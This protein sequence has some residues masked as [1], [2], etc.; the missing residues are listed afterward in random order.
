[1]RAIPLT[2]GKVAL[3]DDADYDRISRFKWYAR[4]GSRASVFYANRKVNGKHVGMHNEIMGAAP[5]PSM[6][7]DHRDGN[8]LNN[9]RSNLRWATHAQQR[10]NI[11][12]AK[13]NTSGFKGVRK[14][15]SPPHAFPWT[16]QIHVNRKCLFLGYFS[17]LGTAAAAYNDAALKYFGKFARLNKL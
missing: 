2:Q 3:V 4:K 6:T 8:G 5:D 9:Q 12:L 13:N 11:P 7:P 15:T 17:T 1:M 16:A 14:S 10:Y